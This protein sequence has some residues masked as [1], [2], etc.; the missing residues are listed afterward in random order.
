MKLN[1]SNKEIQEYLESLKCVYHYSGNGV[2]LNAMF[3]P[4]NPKECNIKSTEKC[5]TTGFPIRSL[6]YTPERVYLGSESYAT[7]SMPIM[8]LI[9]CEQGKD[10]P[11]HF[12]VYFCH[13]RTGGD[14]ENVFYG[15]INSVQDIKDVFRLLG[16]NSEHY[17]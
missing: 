8:H 1:I 16:I 11:Y 10:F 6:E 12:E 5:K 3:S 4:F 2:G 9:I 13:T 7:Y 17:E 15:Y 14:W